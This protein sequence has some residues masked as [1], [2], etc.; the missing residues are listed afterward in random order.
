MY[1]MGKDIIR[2][3]LNLQFSEGDSSL[4]FLTPLAQCMFTLGARKKRGAASRA[5]ILA[6]VGKI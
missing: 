5:E 6:G 3:E 1:L 2:E 4:P